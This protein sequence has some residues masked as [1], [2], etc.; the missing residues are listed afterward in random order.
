M[1][2]STVELSRLCGLT[3]RQSLS[4]QMNKPTGQ[5]LIPFNEGDGLRVTTCPIVASFLRAGRWW[6]LS[7]ERGAWFMSDYL[8]G[9]QVCQGKSK[10]DAEEG[11]NN[12]LERH[13]DFNYAQFPD[14]NSDGF[15]SGFQE[16]L[17][18]VA[19]LPTDAYRVGLEV[20][21]RQGAEDAMNGGTESGS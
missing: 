9:R 20:A 17:R 19:K 2:F 14:L 12:H 15:M 4:G 7:G 1:Q 3:Q 11:L 6:V 10:K 21:L 8:T 16:G 18:L 13:P 5:F